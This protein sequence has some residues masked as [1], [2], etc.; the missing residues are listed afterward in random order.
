MVAGELPEAEAARLGVHVM[1]CLDC[2]AELGSAER[3]E[4]ELR[5]LPRLDAPADLLARIR[6][7][8]GTV[9]PPGPRPPVPARLAA[10][11]LLAAGL[12]L[13]A[14]LGWR[15][16]RDSDPPATAVAPTAAPADVVQ[17][18]AEARLALAVVARLG[19]KAHDEVRE[20]VFVERVATPVLE[21]LG[22]R[23]GARRQGG[24][25]S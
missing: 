22:Q 12:A 20:E 14:G 21:S 8:P 4:A 15:A 24:T 2:A 10:A 19:R 23:G 13:A 5:A 3:V 7:I 25:E 16:S 1:E 18:T 9:T 17:A 11:A 6:A